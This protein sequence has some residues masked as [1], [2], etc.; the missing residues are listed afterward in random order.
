[1]EAYRLGSEEGRAPTSEHLIVPT[2]NLTNRDVR[3]A[4]GDSTRTWTG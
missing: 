4:L 1:V 2:I 3:K